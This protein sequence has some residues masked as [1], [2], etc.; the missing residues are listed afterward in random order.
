M[1]STPISSSA[2]TPANHGLG[3]ERAESNNFDE[4]EKPVPRKENGLS[5]EDNAFLDAFTPQ[6]R[7]SAL[8]KVDFHLI[9]L[10]AIFFLFA[11]LDR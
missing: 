4:V 10:L 2:P 1:V 3:I 5:D 6:Q 7:K 11:Y 9:P 8:R